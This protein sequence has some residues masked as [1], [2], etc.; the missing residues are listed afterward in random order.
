MYGSWRYIVPQNGPDF[1]NYGFLA[2][3]SWFFTEKA[4]L[5]GRYDWISP[6]NQPGSLDNFNSVTLGLNFLP[7]TFTN[8]YKLTLE[9]SY[10]LDSISSTI[11]PTGSG[12]GYLPTADD[13]QFLLR[14]QL[15][16]GF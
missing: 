7:F 13:G 14:L 12:L 10:V 6:G 1:Q 8:R 5:Y 15:Q 2:Q 16:F 4:A 11:V 9:T 3:A